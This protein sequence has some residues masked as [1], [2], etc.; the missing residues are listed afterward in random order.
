MAVPGLFS[1]LFFLVVYFIAFISLNFI[2][3]GFY[4][5]TVSVPVIQCVHKDAT[6][7]PSSVY[8]HISRRG[9]FSFVTRSKPVLSDADVSA[10]MHIDHHL[11][12]IL[13]SF[14]EVN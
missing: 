7:V 11:P 2:L 12:F 13:F 6:R 3:F 5:R 4:L 8:I 1:P 9:H 10:W 14:V